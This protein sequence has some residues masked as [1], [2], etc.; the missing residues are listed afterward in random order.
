MS[1]SRFEVNITLLK[2]ESKALEDDARKYIF[3]KGDSIHK[4]HRWLQV[5]NVINMDKV[6]KSF[7]DGRLHFDKSNEFHPVFYT[8]KKD[9]LETSHS[10][11]E[12][13]CTQIKDSNNVNFRLNAYRIKSDCDAAEMLKTFLYSYTSLDCTASIQLMYNLTLYDVIQLIHGEKANSVFNRLFGSHR[14][15]QER[16]TINNFGVY[17]S[18]DKTDPAS[19]SQYFG[20]AIGGISLQDLIKHPDYYIGMQLAAQGHKN[21]LDKHPAGYAQG[22]NVIFCGLTKKNEP[23][24][25]AARSSGEG[26]YLTYDELITLLLK[27]YNELPDF[28]SRSQA[29]AEANKD[30]IVGLIPSGS[31]FRLDRL[32]ELVDVDKLSLNLSQWLA[33]KQ[34]TKP[35]QVSPLYVEDSEK[36]FMSPKE[37]IREKIMP[38]RCVD[39]EIKIDDFTSK[40][41]KSDVE[42]EY[43]NRYELFSHKRKLAISDSKLEMQ[44]KRNKIL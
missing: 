10:S 37:V 2:S 14:P 27:G 19:P 30:D 17:L 34:K 9:V 18:K 32:L 12:R 44:N 15:L 42:K 26:Y 41:R 31:Y 23:L 7:Y 33:E 16:F 28:H 13:I 22:W 6:C 21:Y 1:I 11:L 4:F 43:G 38:F 35:V 24:F 40:K 5:R 29:K 25:L 39:A 20:Q 8:H 3:A 36:F